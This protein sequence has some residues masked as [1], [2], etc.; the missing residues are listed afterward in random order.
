M[1]NQTVLYVAL[2]AGFLLLAYYLYTQF[3]ASQTAAANAAKLQQAQLQAQ[4]NSSAAGQ[5]TAII[6]GIGGAL[7]GLLS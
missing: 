6:N 5:N 1:K 4:V 3:T 2:T 7:T